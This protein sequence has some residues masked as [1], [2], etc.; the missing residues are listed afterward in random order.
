MVTPQPSA[1]PPGAP[2]GELDEITLA[3]AQKGERA[4]WAALV[5][6]H[7]GAVFALVSRILGR[8]RLNTAYQD[9]AQETFLR[10]FRALPTFDRGGPARLSTW[11][12]TI[13]SRLAISELRRR[14]SEYA[15]PY[16]VVDPEAPDD[17][18]A[19]RGVL[20]R[21][22]EKA[23]ADLAAPYRAAFVLRE[24]H[25]L[26]HEEIAR[27]LDIPVGTVKS[28]LARARQELAAT[29]ADLREGS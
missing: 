8:R 2:P 21:A 4:A 10:V 22:L 27:S 26:S 6:H 25:D 19:A 24:L 5:A 13:A 20:A 7:Q 3:R 28:R 15:L 9:L 18:G 12:L 16:D 11:I 1:D 29:L 23:M 14:P 17:G